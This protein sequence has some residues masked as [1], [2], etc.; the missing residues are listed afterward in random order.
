MTS[1]TASDNRGLV[2]APQGAHSVTEN[3]GKRRQVGRE[4]LHEIESMKKI[5]RA[6][7][8]IEKVVGKV[9]K[10]MTAITDA[11][12]ELQTIRSI[13]T[14]SKEAKSHPFT[15]AYKALD[16]IADKI[17][18]D[19]VPVGKIAE[20][21]AQIILEPFQKQQ[22]KAR[23]ALLKIEDEQ[24]RRGIVR[25]DDAMNSLRS[26]TPDFRDMFIDKFNTG[27]DHDRHKMLTMLEWH[28]ERPNPAGYWQ[29]ANARQQW[30]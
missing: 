11:Q 30:L 14:D 5:P 7:G 15:Q 8:K 19:G 6:L 2:H 9:D 29:S 18:Y 25:N 27:S 23:I 21:G 13:A 16:P 22:S 28:G 1:S 3:G 10:A 24:V 4:A 12:T 26:M 17:S 20:A